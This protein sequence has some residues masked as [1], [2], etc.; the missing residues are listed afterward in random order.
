MKE[1]LD[2]MNDLIINDEW[3]FPD[4]AQRAAIVYGIDQ[5]ELEKAYDNQF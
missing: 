5:E 3:E 1:A 2:F 4:A